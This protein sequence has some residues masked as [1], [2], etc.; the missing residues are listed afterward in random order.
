MRT[1]DEVFD[2]LTTKNELLT[3]LIKEGSSSI[4]GL[5]GEITDLQREYDACV[6]YDHAMAHPLTAWGRTAGCG[7]KDKK[8]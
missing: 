2:E 3:K 1:I 6:A 4:R 5:V 8:K 7:C